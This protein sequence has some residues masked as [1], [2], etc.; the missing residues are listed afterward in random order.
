[1]SK[2]KKNIIFFMPSIE[3]GGVEKNLFIIANYLCKKISNLKICSLSINKK[4]EFNKKIKFLTPS[5]KIPKNVNIRIKY[6]I[7]LYVL[8]KFLLN[9]R[10]TVVFTFQANIYCVL[11]CKLLNVKVIVRSNSSPSGWD[12]NFIKKFIYKLI[13]MKADKIIVNSLEF[14]KQMKK[15]LNLKTQCIFNPFDISKMLK[16]SKIIK[17]ELFFKEKKIIKLINIGR[18][19]DQKDQLTILRAAKILKEKINFRL[20]I[21][22]YGEKEKEL[23]KYIVDNNLT[24][25]VKIKK[26]LSSP[27][28]L[29]NQSDIFILSSKYEGLPNVLL[30]AAALKKFI[31]ST[32]CPTGPK[33]IIING[34]GGLFFKIGDHYDLSHKILFYLKNKKKL[35]KKISITYKGL[36]RYNFKKNLEKYNNLILNLV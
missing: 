11:L 29:L 35:N 9:N 18:F 28:Q 16:K 22:G 15:K 31:I 4:K 5:T 19:T 6:L 32:N 36:S 25:Y 17:K 1:M 13:M 2:N 34:K 33:E 10:N 23:L 12:H 7:C 24:K 8:L 30:E 14:Q 27:Y 21:I 20:I 3:S 26:I